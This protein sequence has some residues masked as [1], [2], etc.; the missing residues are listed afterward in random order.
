MHC[1]KEFGAHKGALISR[2]SRA[3]GQA[4]AARRHCD[5][6]WRIVRPKQKRLETEKRRR[7]N[8]SRRQQLTVRATYSRYGRE[9]GW[10]LAFGEVGGCGLL[11]ARRQQRRSGPSCEPIV[12]SPSS[13][14]ARCGNPTPDE[15]PPCSRA[16]RT[17]VRT[18]SRPAPPAGSPWKAP[19]RAAIAC[20]GP[21]SSRRKDLRGGSPKYRTRSAN[22]R[23]PERTWSGGIGGK[24]RIRKAP[25]FE[26]LGNARIP[27]EFPFLIRKLRGRL[28]A[29]TPL[30]IPRPPCY[31]VIA[32]GC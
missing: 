18:G 23:Y 11:A 13:T 24:R 19:Q 5:K 26:A 29:T 1:Q 17:Q 16:R 30:P 10:Y 27:T 6:K 28:A 14:L 32:E 25:S 22:L 20:R 8:V 15:R 4:I 12:R 21:G 7:W 3:A 2:P 31:H 9:H